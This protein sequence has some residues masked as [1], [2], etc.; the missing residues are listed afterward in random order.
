MLAGKRH[1]TDEINALFFSH[2]A[3]TGNPALVNIKDIFSAEAQDIESDM[4]KSLF[5]C[6]ERNDL[7]KGWTPKHPVKLY[8]SK[9]D[10]VV[11]FENAQEALAAFGKNA[12]LQVVENEGHVSSCTMWMFSLFL[13]GV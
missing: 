4:M 3:A 9:G 2:L 6:F 1:T 8:H 12:T 5:I 13:A 10:R 11:P 7:T